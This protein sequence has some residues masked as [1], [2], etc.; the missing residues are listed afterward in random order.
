VREG[1]VLLVYF[2][3]FLS[4]EI[5]STL[6]SL[7]RQRASMRACGKWEYL[8]GSMMI[9]LSWFMCSKGALQ[10]SLGMKPASLP[11]ITKYVSSPPFLL[12]TNIC[13]LHSRCFPDKNRPPKVYRDLL[14][15]STPI[16]HLNYFDA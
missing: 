4:L 16:D 9:V 2:F 11:I 8:S 6:A 10:Y 7:P 14:L 1:F 15:T 12:I 5:V 3:P 13:S